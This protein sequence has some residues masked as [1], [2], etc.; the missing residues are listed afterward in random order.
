[1]QPAALHR[2]LTNLVRITGRSR[3][4]MVVYT[5]IEANTC[6]SLEVAYTQGFASSSPGEPAPL[7]RDRMPRFLCIKLPLSSLHYG[8]ALHVE[9]C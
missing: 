2:G 8:G 5:A 1:M 9:S 6:Q 3:K 4:S 7:P